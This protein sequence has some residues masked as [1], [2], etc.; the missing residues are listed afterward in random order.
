[1]SYKQK[2]VA[3]IV[4]FNRLSKLQYALSCYEKQTV[5]FDTLII[6]DNNS[7]DGT[8]EFLKEWQENNTKYNKHVIYLSTNVGGS[9][10]FYAGEEYAM[11]LNPEWIYIADDDAYPEIDMVE[12]FLEF[13]SKHSNEKIAAI[14]TSVWD[15]T[16][17]IMY[18][19]RSHA[20]F[21]NQKLS[22]IPA[23]V[24]EYKMHFFEF[25]CLSYV[26]GFISAE[27]MKERGLVN[28]D[29]FIYQDDVEHSLRL[30]KYGKM[31][32]VP[33]IK[34]IHDSVPPGFMTVAQISKILWKE[35]YAVRNRGY[36]LLKINYIIGVKYLFNQLYNIKSHK[37][38][39]LS[40]TDK[41]TI[42]ASKDAFMGRLGLHSVYR[43]GL[44]VDKTTKLPYPRILWKIL[45]YIF[46]FIK[47]IRKN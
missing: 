17:T 15:M 24:D 23:S 4:T 2:V 14:C 41:M 28:K 25:N 45:Y 39:S 13:Y 40:P 34:V 43:P 38:K 29:F 26:G 18:G 36:M 46:R 47:L 7:T 32:C 33:S 42:Q 3:V 31:Y 8:I 27:A 5:P 35:Y 6:V 44:D 20:K 9:G 19:C 37:D 12:K 22:I 21:S 16:N 11:S 10:G 1:M 30:N